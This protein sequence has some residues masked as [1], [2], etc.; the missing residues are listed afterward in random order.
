MVS[1]T[2]TLIATLL[3]PSKKALK[4]N[5]PTNGQCR[6]LSHWN[7]VLGHIVNPRS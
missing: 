3:E 2:I 6:G 7:R 5:D 4:P 1:L